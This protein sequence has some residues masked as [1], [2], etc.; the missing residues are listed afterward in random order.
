M[1]PG[2]FLVLGAL[3]L[4]TPVFAQTDTS[5]EVTAGVFVGRIPCELGVVVELLADANA[6]GQFILKMNKMT[7]QL[8]PVQT[9][10]GVVRLEDKKAGAVWLQIA[11]KSMLMNQKLGRRLADEC[12]S[13]AQAVAAQAMKA[14]PVPGLLDAAIQAPAGPASASL[15]APEL[16]SLPAPAPASSA[17]Q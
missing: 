15:P 2:R 1:D 5:V 13:P 6:P 3:L 9:S 11:N 12:I 16:A 10:T 8:S 4:A 7:Y 17:A 14:N